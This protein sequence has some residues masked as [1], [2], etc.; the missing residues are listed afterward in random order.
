[1]GITPHLRKKAGAESG[2]CGAGPAREAGPARLRRV[3]LRDL[4][5]LGSIGVYEREKR[6]AQRILISFE[7]LI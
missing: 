2:R 6:Y 4:Y 3:F 7:H 1:M 5:T